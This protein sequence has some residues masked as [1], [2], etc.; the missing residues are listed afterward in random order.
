MGFNGIRDYRIS[1]NFMSTNGDVPGSTMVVAEVPF[2]SNATSTGNPYAA[3]YYWAIT[4]Q[5]P[6][7][8]TKYLYQAMFYNP[9]T[10]TLNVEV[11]SEEIGLSTGSTQDY[12]RVNTFQ[13]PGSTAAGL[14]RYITSPQ[15]GWFNGCCMQFRFYNASTYANAETATNY[16]TYM[17]IKEYL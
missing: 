4:Y 5:K 3:D 11:L 10:N 7:N 9:T 2:S 15:E 17:A 6:T 13:I 14:G 12:M 16:K 8:N 1:G